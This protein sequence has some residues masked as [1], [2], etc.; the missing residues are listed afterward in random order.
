MTPDKSEPAQ[1]WTS[2]EAAE[3]WHRLGDRRVNLWRSVSERML[4]LA[5]VG[6]GSR[7]LDVAAGT[8]D[9]A[10]LAARRVGPSGHVLA[11]D[12]STHMLRIAAELVRQAGVTNVETHVMD[13]ERVDLPPDTFDAVICRNGLMFI[14]DLQTALL[15]MHR[16]L[17][18]GGKIAAVVFSSE[19][20]NPVVAIPLEIVRRI[21]HLPRRAPGEPGW[22]ALGAPAVLEAA[23]R[24]AGFRDVA[25]EP[26]STNR[27][28]ASVQDVVRT[29]R[30]NPVLSEPLSRLDS[31]EREQASREMAEA[32]SRFAG[33]DGFDAPGESLIA[34]GTK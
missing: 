22:F 26:I 13:A 2:P 21:G 27:R 20:Q 6:V 8:G 11:T 17:R 14:P 19:E 5:S 32:L 9:D 24:A 28:A 30:D 18:P 29:L 4:D 1:I 12:L 10:L 31:A 3:A 25:V 7:V 33:P 23:F 15:G 34:A 16:V